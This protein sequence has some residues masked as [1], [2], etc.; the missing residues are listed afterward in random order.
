MTT[1]AAP[2][3]S[4]TVYSTGQTPEDITALFDLAILSGASLDQFPVPPVLTDPNYVPPRYSRDLLNGFSTATA[5]LATVM[6]SIRLYVRTK[7]CRGRYSTDDYCLAI[8]YLM[9]ATQVIIVLVGV[10]RFQ[11]GSHTYDMKI[12]SLLLNYKFVYI[13]EML[14]TSTL[15]MI[16]LS[17]LFFLGRLFREASKSFI[18]LNNALIVCNIIFGVASI[19][20]YTFQCGGD[21]RP[22]WDVYEKFR[23]GCK[24][25]YI[26]YVISAFQLAL[27]FAS[28]IV[29]IR[30]VRALRGL[31]VRKKIEVLAMFS[32]GLS[33]CVISIA[34]C[35]YLAPVVESLDQSNASVNLT[36][37][38][39]LEGMVAIVAACIPA[40]R[41]FFGGLSSE[42]QVV[43]ITGKVVSS[44]RSIASSTS[45]SKRSSV[46][47][48]SSSQ[49]RSQTGRGLGERDSQLL[50]SHY[51]RI[52]GTD[53]D[54]EM[55]G[56]PV[57]GKNGGLNSK[58]VLEE[59][60][61]IEAGP[62]VIEG[63]SGKD[64]KSE[65]GKAHR[66]WSRHLSK[67][68][69]KFNHQVSRFSPTASPSSSEMQFGTQVQPATPPR[70][71]SRRTVGVSEGR[72]DL[73]TNTPSFEI[74]AGSGVNSSTNSLDLSHWDTLDGDH[75]HHPASLTPRPTSSGKAGYQDWRDSVRID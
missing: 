71:M 62:S 46:M 3:P 2:G 36:I 44:F 28:V 54:V 72:R 51:G 43:R 1:V 25:V 8:G 33:A 4:Q 64:D 16:R 63:G 53:E 40:A 24:P 67:S 66:Q 74:T 10:N 49:A 20:A 41:Q 52:I 34:R 61:D 48:S 11:W 19:F 58:G 6:V 57:D 38:C 65:E 47:L 13:F 29:P 32:L 35:V 75:D 21:I 60:R 26:Y 55:V 50:Q 22:A 23:S 68:R 59:E 30:L 37:C 69:L 14:F 70:S 31:S 56:S 73:S 17:L 7:Q 9:L 45:P 15:V 5:I 27:D 18:Y 42:P 12:S 39:L